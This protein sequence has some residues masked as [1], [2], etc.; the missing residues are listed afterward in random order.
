MM[1]GA[2]SYD[3]SILYRLP[4]PMVFPMILT[5]HVGTSSTERNGSTSLNRQA[6]NWDTNRKVS[7]TVTLILFIFTAEQSRK[8]PRTL[9]KRKAHELED[10][11]TSN[12]FQNLFLELPLHLL[13]LVIG[14]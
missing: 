3:N 6:T 2:G 10:S 5:W 13:T 8:H 11:R 1:F 9:Q 14:G 4:V 12:I 7:F